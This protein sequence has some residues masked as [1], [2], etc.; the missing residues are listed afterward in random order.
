MSEHPVDSGTPVSQDT[1]PVSR[2][3]NFFRPQTAHSTADMRMIVSLVLVWAVAVFGFQFLLIAFN[4]P[5][6]EPA[7]TSFQSIW[8]T[9]NE[10]TADQAQ[11]QEFARITLSVLGKNI[12]VK[13]EH[14]EILQD[15]LTK[16]TAALL[17]EPQRQT[18]LDS[19]GSGAGMSDAVNQAASAIGLES[20]GF[21]KLR[22]DLLPYSLTPV[23][24]S[25]LSSEL[26]AIMELYLVHNQSF[27]TDVQFIGFPFHYWYTAQFLLILFVILC[28]IYARTTDQ[29]NAKYNFSDE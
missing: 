2:D 27:L 12:A 6:P 16:T 28:L 17:P 3:V 25:E 15:A 24:G 9:V 1:Q 18:F 13:P 21:D 29:L 5:T 22:M 7:Y 23:A 10:G 14:K 20:T 19:L 26:P 11:Q 8:S 4:Q